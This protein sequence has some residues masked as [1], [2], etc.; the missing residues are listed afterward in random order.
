LAIVL[1]VVKVFPQAQW[2]VQVWYRGWI[3]VFTI[4]RNSLSDRASQQ[5][6]HDV[7]RAI[8]ARDH[9]N[10]AF[11][12]QRLAQA[13]KTLHLSSSA[14]E[15]RALKVFWS[16][17]LGFWS[18]QSVMVPARPMH[19]PVRQFILCCLSHGHHFHIELQRHA[20]QRMICIDFDVVPFDGNHADDLY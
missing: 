2:T 13:P 10:R 7:S 4:S 14:I 18:F 11:A 8:K 16:L 20:R 3:L 9:S 5:K 15:V 1:R 6:R 17:E 12:K 19:V